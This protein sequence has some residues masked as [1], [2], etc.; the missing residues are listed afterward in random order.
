MDP[1]ETILEDRPEPGWKERIGAVRRAAAA[2][3]ATRGEI[4]REELSEKGSL[5]AKAA[6]GLAL[7]AAFGVFA[8]L[9]LTALVAA[10]F[11]RLFGGPIAGITATLVLYLVVA[12]LAGFFGGRSLSRVRPFAFPATRDE[13]RKDLDAVKK[14]GD[15]SD[16]AATDAVGDDAVAA[17]RASMQPDDE[18]GDDEE[19]EEIEEVDE[20]DDD[21]EGGIPTMSELEDRFR[22]GSE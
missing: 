13:I 12:G 2:L 22:A 9:L 16:D 10:V 17:E 6:V 14:H 7:A 5:F 1:E 19:V 3:A 21:R 20:D 4:F 8:L 18:R 11:S 15:V